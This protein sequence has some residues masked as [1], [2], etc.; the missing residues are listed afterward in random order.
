MSCSICKSRTVN[1][2]NRIVR[3]FG[4]YSQ[5]TQVCGGVVVY[6][7]FIKNEQHGKSISYAADTNWGGKWVEAM[8]AREVKEAFHSEL[9]DAFRKGIHSDVQV[10]PSSGPYIRAH[11]VLLATRSEILKNM[12]ESDWCKAAP[13]DSISLPDFSHE[14]L[15]TFLEFLCFGDLPT[16]KFQKH[17]IT[18]LTAADKYDI[19]DLQKF[20]EQQL[21]KQLNSS[22]ALKILEISDVVSNETIKLAALKLIVQQHKEIVLAPSFNVFAKKNPHLATEVA[23]AALTYPTEKKI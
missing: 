5:Y 19:G 1:I 2:T 6:N 17:C 21:I 20:S 16:E 13:E 14:E 18:L 7:N 4:L 9:A 15:D 10:K 22:N 11:R 3:D 12:L 8:E 23:R